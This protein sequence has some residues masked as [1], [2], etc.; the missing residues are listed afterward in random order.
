MSDSDNRGGQDGPSSPPIPFSNDASVTPP[1][2]DAAAKPAGFLGVNKTFSALGVPAYRLLWLSTLCGFLGMQM[3]MVARGLLAYEIGG[4]NSAIAV[5]SLA[6]GIPMLLFSLIGGTVADRF[7]RRKLMIASQAGT[8]AVAISVAVLVQTGAIELWHLFATGLIQGTIFSFGGPAR[9]AFIPEV[10]GE[11]QLL[12]AIA[13]NNAGMN[14][15]RIVG[16]SIAGALIAVPWVDI[17][18]VFFIQAA[19]N[20]AALVQLA[21]LPLIMRRAPAEGAE[22]PAS[23]VW[24]QSTSPEEPRSVTGQLVDGLRYILASPILLT[25]LAMGLVPSMLGM[26]YQTFLPVF[27]QDVFGNGVDRNSEGLGL[28]MTMTGVGAL[29]GSL[30]VASMQDYPRR[31]LLQLISGLGFG[32]SLAFFAVQSSFVMAIVGLTL[33]GFMANFFQALNSTM[34]MSASDPRYYGRVMSVNMMTFALMPLG[35]LPIGFIADLIG[36]MSAPIE[37]IGI[38]IAHLGAG[39]IIVVFILLVT[40][41][42]RAYRQLE[43]EDF[44]HFA[45]MAA[46]RVQDDRSGSVWQ[47]LRR[48][49]Q[50]ERGS[51]LARSQTETESARSDSDRVLTP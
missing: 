4:T 40:V 23:A 28:M 51:S 13:L 12:N 25:L 17:E 3:Q 21:L 43:Q 14:L 31:T 19:L 2:E 29:I 26:S 10:V 11:K 15:T 47:Q 18:G 5:V 1:P 6:W 9:Q 32:L 44:K 48:S 33:I 20:G 50:Q 37:L 46:E 35:T 22:A 45:T 42:N 7:E 49:A 38:Q 30:V 27:A 24:Q 41:K 34:V 8:A 36:S 16:P 39:A